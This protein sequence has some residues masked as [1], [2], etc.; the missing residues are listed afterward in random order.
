MEKLKKETNKEAQ[1]KLEIKL[2]Q[3]VKAT[4]SLLEPLKKLNKEQMGAVV[5]F[6]YLIQGVKLSDPYPFGKDIKKRFEVE[7]HNIF[8]DIPFV[9]ERSDPCFDATVEYLIALKNCSKDHK[10]EEECPE[11]EVP[12]AQARV[13]TMKRLDKM[14]DIIQDIWNQQRPPRP[15]PWPI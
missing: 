7:L 4:D 14:R 15:S 13:C 6:G 1:K 11:A 8:P 2:D 5:A 3:M 9:I 10:K 12:G